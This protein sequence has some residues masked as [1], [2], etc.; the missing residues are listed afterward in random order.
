MGLKFHAA[1]CLNVKDKHG[2]AALLCDGGIQLAQRSGR[3]VARIGKQPLSQELLFLIDPLKCRVFHINFSA[4]LQIFRRAFQLLLHVAYH[5]GICRHI[6]PEI[7]AVSPRLREHQL[8]VFIAERHGE[9]VNL[10]FHDKF[11]FCK[12]FPHL[13]NKFTD[14]LPGKNI[15][16]AQHRNIVAHQHSGGPLRRSPYF[17]RRRILRHQIRMFLFELFEL[18]HQQIKLV[19]RNL[20]TVLVIIFITVVCNLFPQL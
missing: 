19:I 18:P 4:D 5:P 1:D 17:L 14:L 12:L 6:L 20:R 16:K 2:Q 3:A 9:P 8:T 10:V 15:L 7:D 13:P 11:R